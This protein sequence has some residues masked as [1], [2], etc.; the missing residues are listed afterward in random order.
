MVHVPSEFWVSENEE[1][2]IYDLHDNQI[3]D[4]GYRRFLSRVFDPLNKL[5]PANSSGLDFGCGPGPALAAMLEE[6][7]HSVSLYDIFYYPDS[8]VLNRQYQFIT[9]TEVVEHLSQP[10]QELERLWR[11]L[12]PGGLLGI[13]TKKV[14]D[15]EAFSRWH[16]KND[17]THIC[18]FAERSF[19]Y[20]SEQWGADIVHTGKDVI[21]FKKPVS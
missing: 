8:A 12:E 3:D 18:F 11:C 10:K 20:L 19:E 16:Y 21:I 2:A 15:K 13:M 5:L 1:K 17:L 4:Q 14:Q 9:A 6:A 7:G